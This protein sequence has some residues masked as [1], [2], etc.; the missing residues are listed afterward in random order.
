MSVLTNYPWI[1]TCFEDVK[2]E[3]NGFRCT[4]ECSLRCHKQAR[5]QFMLGEGGRLLVKC[6]RGCNALEMLRAVGASWR[7]CFPD[8][9][10]PDR[11]KQEIA[12]KYPYC[13]AEGRVKYQT[14]RLEP[15][16][17]GRDKDFKQRRPHP[18]G[19]GWINNLDGVDRILYRLPELMAAD[20]EVPALIC[21]GEKDVETLRAIGFVAT[22]NVCGE[23]AEWLDSYSAALKGR[24]VVVIPDGDATGKRHA[25]E[26]LGSLLGY[27]RSVRRVVL[28][29]PLKDPTALV[30]HLR[31]N[32]VTDPRELRRHVAQVIGEFHRWEEKR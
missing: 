17:Y 9:K 12:A 27:A 5:A 25:N 22:T 16:C 29:A 28:P 4:S 32:G 7:D 24:H 26:V 2:E 14:I 19:E 21:S 3:A 30:T 23:K 11:P 13:D 8:G 20:P 31:F 10:M 6:W 1:A 15:G 18:C